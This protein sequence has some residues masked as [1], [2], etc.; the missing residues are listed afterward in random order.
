MRIRGKMNGQHLH[1]EHKPPE[2]GNFKEK[3][4]VISIQSIL[5]DDSGKRKFAWRRR[6]ST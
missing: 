6:C 1:V 5:D 4:E 2:K 3:I